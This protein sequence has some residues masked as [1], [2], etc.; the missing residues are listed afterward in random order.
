MVVKPL[1]G[2]GRVVSADNFFIIATVQY[3]LIPLF[4]TGCE[5][6]GLFGKGDRAEQFHIGK[7]SLLFQFDYD[8]CRPCVNAYRAADIKNLYAFLIQ[9][10]YLLRKRRLN[11]LA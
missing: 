10:L 3:V 1:I 9:R 8:F 4:L 6:I 5:C 7:S 11:L 2:Y